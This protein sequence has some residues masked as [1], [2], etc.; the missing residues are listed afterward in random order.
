MNSTPNYASI[1]LRST[2]SNS[3][4]VQPGKTFVRA[5]TA[6]LTWQAMGSIAKDYISKNTEPRSCLC[7]NKAARI[8]TRQR[9]PT[10]VATNILRLAGLRARWLRMITKVDHDPA[11]P[12]W[13]FCC[14]PLVPRKHTLGVHPSDPQVQPRRSTT[15]D[16]DETGRTAYLRRNYNV[17]NVDVIQRKSQHGSPIV[18]SDLRVHGRMPMGGV[19]DVVFPG[20]DRVAHAGSL[21]RGGAHLLVHR[22]SNRGLGG[23][24]ALRCRI[25]LCVCPAL[26]RTATYTYSCSGYAS[27]AS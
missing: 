16:L 3:L 1:F 19:A 4:R 10:S 17:E 11:N 15:G 13:Q 22:A 23:G 21:C 5:S 18:R 6:S 9:E 14:D 24:V 8:H 26:R 20:W 12:D 27:M 7:P 25:C 2:L